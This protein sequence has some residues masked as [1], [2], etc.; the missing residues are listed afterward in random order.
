MD[1]FIFVH[2]I[3]LKSSNWFQCVFGMNFLLATSIECVNSLFY[4]LVGGKQMGFF[5]FLYV[6]GQKIT[7]FIGFSDGSLFSSDP[8]FA[9]CFIM[10]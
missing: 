6:S 8:T 2:H 3:Y 5:M 7:N 1:S 4:F 10:Y 9:F